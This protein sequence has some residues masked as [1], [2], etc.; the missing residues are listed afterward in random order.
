MLVPLVTQGVNHGD[1]HL[2]V[3]DDR[4]SYGRRGFLIA[5]SDKV[6]VT[7]CSVTPCEC[8]IAKDNVAICSPLRTASCREAAASTVDRRLPPL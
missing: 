1:H 4:G 3:T 2:V 8:H 5:L 7:Y 6:N